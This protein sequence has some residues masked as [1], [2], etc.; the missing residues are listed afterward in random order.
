MRVTHV[1]KK[2]ASK[3]RTAKAIMSRRPQ[4]I[5][6]DDD[7]VLARQIMLWSGIRHLPVVKGETLV[8]MLSDRDILGAGLQ[9]GYAGKRVADVMAKKV[10]WVDP[11]EDIES[12]A[13][14][15]AA[16]KIGAVPVLLN[17]A[18]IGIVTT[19][20]VLADRSL[21]P[22]DRG[23]PRLE[24]EPTA[25]D[26]MTKE[27]ECVTPETPL[28]AAI[29]TMTQMGVRHLP[30][31]DAAHRLIGIVSDRDVRQ[32]VGDPLIAIRERREDDES[33]VSDVMSEDP[34]RVAADA[35]IL[36][37]AELFSDEKVGAIPVVDE[38]D[39]PIGIISYVDLISWQARRQLITRGRQ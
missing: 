27:P 26:V 6:P 35:P 16:L 7:L 2:R 28:Y 1:A 17:G 12:V 14:R 31:I 34:V 20:D 8:G 9:G 22:L 24:K 5:R 19:T 4:T 33:A 13:A 30:V 25:R 32:A 15:M 21:G 10:Y 18:L 38:K 3:R 36:T 37:V 23:A 11:D 39:R 29:E